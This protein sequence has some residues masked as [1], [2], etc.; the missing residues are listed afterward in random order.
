M[1][2][3]AGIAWEEKALKRHPHDP[4]YLAFLGGS[5]MKLGTPGSLDRAAEALRESV[6]LLPDDA[7]YRDMYAQVLHRLGRYDEARRQYLQALD[8]DP[9][10]ISCYTPVAQLAWR[11]NRPGAAAFFPPVIRSVQQRL[12]EESV[13]WRRVWDHPEDAAGRL[14]LAH[15][16][17]RTADLTKARHQL[18]QVLELRPD[19]R[20]ARRL[21]TTVQ[22]AQEAL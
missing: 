18:E 10:R 7:E 8:N 11:L 1:N 4:H 5:L 21:L 2:Y 3:A 6:S 15:F 9:F 14:K 19:S 12:S 22:R 16:L 20:E 13:L 17:C